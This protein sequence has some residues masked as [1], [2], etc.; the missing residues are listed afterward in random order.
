MN[1][2]DDHRCAARRHAQHR[3]WQRYGVALGEPDVARLERQIADG[4]A[5]LL[6]EPRAGGRAWL[7][8]YRGV[9]AIAVFSDELG[10]IVTFLPKWAMKEFVGAGQ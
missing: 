3:F 2:C 8:R 5:R 7:V 6:G 9:K 10:C 1:F 4:R